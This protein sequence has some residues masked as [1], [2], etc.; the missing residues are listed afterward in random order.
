[1]T[2]TLAKWFGNPAVYHLEYSSDLTLRSRLSWC[3]ALGFRVA[4]YKSGVLHSDYFY[5]A[6]SSPLLLR[7]A[8]DTARILCRNFAPKSHRQLRVKDLPKVH[9]AARAGVKPTNQRTKGVDSTNAP[10]T[11]HNYYDSVI[12]DEG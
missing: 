1:M 6:S 11:L 2:V 9:T 4:L 10:P 5:R 3:H 12:S 7:G 8:P